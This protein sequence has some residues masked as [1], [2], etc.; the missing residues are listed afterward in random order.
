M[1][2][3]ALGHLEVS[4]DPLKQKQPGSRV[5]SIGVFFL[6]LVSLV[7]LKGSL[8]LEFRLVSGASL[9]RFC[10]LVRRGRATRTVF[11][12][13]AELVDSTHFA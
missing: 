3:G 2:Y 11:T 7:V 5:Q 6:A 4:L 8:S 10:E 13:L 12:P 9:S 1:T